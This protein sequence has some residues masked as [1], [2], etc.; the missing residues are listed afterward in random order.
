MRHYL[1]LLLVI[2]LIVGSP[3]FLVSLSAKQEGKSER[4]SRMKWWRDARFGLFIHWGLYSIPAGEWRGK[5]EYGEWIRTS[6]Q[7]PLEE[8]DKF[9]QQFNPEKFNAAEWV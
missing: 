8:Y 2:I 3:A 5:T 7:I 1:L 9:L 6:A 4:D